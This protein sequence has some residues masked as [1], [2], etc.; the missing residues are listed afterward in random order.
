MQV[1]LDQSSANAKKRKRDQSMEPPASDL[2]LRRGVLPAAPPDRALPATVQVVYPQ[3]V[4]WRK[5]PNYNDRI[6]EIAG[7]SQM[8]QL[9]GQIVQGDVR[10]LQV[11]MQPGSPHQ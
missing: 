8:S 9:Q 10:Y 11:Q 6:T 2:V 1:A 7:P 5:S 4:A 3:G